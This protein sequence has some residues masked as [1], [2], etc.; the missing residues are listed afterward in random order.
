MNELELIDLILSR[1]G[2]VGRDARLK[3]GAGDDAAVISWE[4]GQDLVV[5]TDVCLDG[6]HVPYNCPADLIGYRCVAMSISD[7]VAMG[8]MPHYITIALT[9]EQADVNWISD[10]ADG[11]RIGCELSDTTVI[12]GNLAKGEKNI[13]ITAL[14]SVPTGCSIKRNTAELND[15]IWITGILGASVLAVQ[16]IT[17]WSPRTL[18]D[19]QKLTDTDVFARYLIPPIRTDFVGC[20]RKCASACTD[21][22]DGLALE[23]EQLV[24]GSSLGYHV[25][26]DKIPLWDGA[27]LNETL[28]SDDSYEMLFTA[29]IQSRDV[30]E[31]FARATDTL[32]SR[33]G[34]INQTNERKFTPVKVVDSQDLGYGHF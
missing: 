25:Y 20:L 12:G 26:C 1:L 19:L 22:S 18:L 27:H 5:S 32:V 13:A 33:I 29:P 14:G 10:F 7:L 8:A 15:D 24:S 21:I 30:V 2:S 34:S 31:S 23:L 3:I 9:I 6:V 28:D 16:A 4:T 17:S 11:V